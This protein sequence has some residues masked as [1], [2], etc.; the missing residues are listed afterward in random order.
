M[1]KID[2]RSAFNPVCSFYG[3]R[4][5]G[6]ASRGQSDHQDIV[7]QTGAFIPHAHIKVIP[8]AHP[9]P[10]NMETNEAGEPQLQLKIGGHAVF[11]SAQGFKS[12]VRHIEV[13]DSQE[14]QV[15]PI[16]LRIGDTFSPIVLSEEEA[17]ERA[18]KLFLSAMP[19]HRDW[20]ITP[21]EFKAMPH[22]NITVIDSTTAKQ[23]NYSGVRLSDLL[24][25]AGVPTG[26]AWDNDISSSRY[27]I[28]TGNPKWQGSASEVFSLGELQPGLQAGEILI[29]DAKSG[30]PLGYKIGPF[31]LIVSEDK[32]RLRWIE[33]LTELTLQTCS[34]Q[35]IP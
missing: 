16:M 26:V 1:C 3:L 15:I 12:D 24:A 7:D 34:R 17:A 19:F 32:N 4:A 6:A 33:K 22:T 27:L 8:A 28:A 30:Q 25:Q 31:M 18:R 35:L 23:E 2:P 9:L 29:A 20:W 10:E 21:E 13:Q 14:A 5:G 11:S